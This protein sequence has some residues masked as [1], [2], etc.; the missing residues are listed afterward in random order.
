[1]VLNGLG[2]LRTLGDFILQRTSVWKAGDASEWWQSRIQLR[3]I[4]KDDRLE[5]AAAWLPCDRGLVAHFLHRLLNGVK[6]AQKGKTKAA[7]WRTVRAGGCGRRRIHWPGLKSAE[8]HHQWLNFGV[9]MIAFVFFGSCQSSLQTLAC[10]PLMGLDLHTRPSLW[11]R[12]GFSPSG[13]LAPTGDWL[14]IL[15]LCSQTLSLTASSS[16]L[17]SFSAVAEK[18]QW[19]RQ[20]N[21][22]SSFILF[23]ELMQGFALEET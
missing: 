7:R 9:K 10:W 21:F 20:S 6:G 22:L 4:R 16:C 8:S 5:V 17:C 11:K 19:L 1:M 14:E 15:F 12:P 23:D 18:C 3:S 13:H 2:S